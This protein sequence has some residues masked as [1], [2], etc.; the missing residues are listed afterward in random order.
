M[1]GK[2]YLKPDISV[3]RSDTPRAFKRLM[4]DCI[5]FDVSERPLFPQVSHLDC[6]L[7]I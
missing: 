7:V 3:A 4:Q 2:G 5:K 6:H 1:V